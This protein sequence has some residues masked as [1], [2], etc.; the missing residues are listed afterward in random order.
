MKKMA[1]VMVAAAVLAGGVFGSFTVAD[2]THAAPNTKIVTTQQNHK[3]VIEQTVELAKKGKAINSGK[4][5]LQSSGKQIQKEW[6]KPDGEL[7][8]QNY[9]SYK[10]RRIDFEL[11]NDKVKQMITYDN[12]YD[13]ITFE[14]VDK[15]VGDSADRTDLRY[16][17]DGVY[18]TYTFGSRV[19]EFVF[20][21]DDAGREPSTVKEVYVR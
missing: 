14:E 18:L 5:G 6:G 13:D 12:K 1:K 15:T 16:G 20:Y 21:Y 17:E 19:L 4:F 11:K 8:D 9:L 2:V 7:T 3:Q 10:K